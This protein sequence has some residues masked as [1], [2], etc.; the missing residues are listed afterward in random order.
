LAPDAHATGMVDVQLCRKLIEAKARMVWTFLSLNAGLSL[1][2]ITNF[3]H[4]FASATPKTN[5]LTHSW[6]T[7]P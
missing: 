5:Y 7:C 3:H 1:G 4:A 6:T 2:E